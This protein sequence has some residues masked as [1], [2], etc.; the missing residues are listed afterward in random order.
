MEKTQ[1]CIVLTETF[2]NDQ[3]F[4]LREIVISQAREIDQ[5]NQVVVIINRSD[6]NTEKRRRKSKLIH[7]CDKSGKY[8]SK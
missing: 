2:T 3:I 5:Q 8:K 7:D 6:I 4:E 1:L